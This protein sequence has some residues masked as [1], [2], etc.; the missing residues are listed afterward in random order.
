VKSKPLLLVSTAL[1]ALA[2]LLLAQAPATKPL[3][4]NELLK[5]ID[6]IGTR[7]TDELPTQGA[8]SGVDTVRP[9][10]GKLES[11]AK[12]PSQT[13]ITSEKGSWDNKTSQ[14]VFV[15]KVFVKNPDFNVSCD[16]LTATIKAQAKKE[17][18]S[19]AAKLNPPR[20]TTG[21]NGTQV[22]ASGTSAAD[23]TGGL[24]RAVAEGH[25][26]ITRERLDSD[27]NVARDIGRGTKAVYDA[28]TGD[29]TLT[30]KPEVSQGINTCVALDEKTVII[31][32]RNGKM[33]TI[34]P[35]KTII[36]ENTGDVPGTP[37]GR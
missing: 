32:N 9:P 36:R 21:Q 1:L 7:R 34:G 15:D 26:V 4:E 31:M 35:T 3:T 8:G 22:D 12:K 24:E 10:K 23:K 25:V 11:G 14:A 18:D 28:A 2:P 19:G 5:T 17:D 33:T 6:S 29:V 30:G 27:G 13:E 37:N 20:L 16:K